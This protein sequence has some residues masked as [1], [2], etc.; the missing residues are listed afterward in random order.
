GYE[1][2]F[3]DEVTAFDVSA[4]PNRYLRYGFLSDFHPA[5]RD[6]ATD[7]D[8]LLRYRI[9]AVQ[10]YDWM[11]RHHEFLPPTE[12]FRDAM[13]RPVDLGAV[14]A[15]LASCRERGQ[16]TLAY[17]AVYGAEAEYI[18]SRPDQRL[19]RADGSPLVF[20]G[21]I[22]F[23]NIAPGNPWVAQIVEQYRRT[24]ADLG[25]DGIH[26]DQYGYPKVAFDA[27]GRAVDLEAAFVN[28]IGE[29]KSALTAVRPDNTVLFN[30]VGD[31][32]TTRVAPA[33]QDG[34][35]I[36]VWD[37]HAT[38][39]HLMALV[40]KAKALAPGKTVILAAYLHCFN[41]PGPDEPKIW[42]A[43]TATAFIAAAG[44]THLLWGETCGALAEGYYVNHRTY[45]PVWE[46]VIRGYCEFPVKYRDW[47]VGQAEDV[48]WDR[49]DG[50]NR[51]FLVEGWT[52]TP[53][54][55]KP[56]LTASLRR[57]PGT[58]VVQLLHPASQGAPVWNARASRPEVV[59]NLTLR[60]LVEGR[61]ARV[62]TASPDFDGGRLFDLPFTQERL[63]EGTATVVVLPRLRLWSL[64][65]IL[66]D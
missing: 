41:E 58:L 7:V 61:P 46:P 45:D 3:G 1:V 16:R 53:D 56:G 4:D 39:G 17:G 25:F 8:Q 9:N 50:P 30:A 26:M 40:R 6:D 20:I 14:K 11:Y 43:L 49:V 37:P 64:V 38:L 66:W 35:Y 29:T 31:W 19:Y 44:G 21:L 15:K 48:S 42:G 65:A 23:C 47:I 33:P 52:V 59:E 54:G 22:G 63:E 32:P 62:V 60:I 34:V 18:D 28:L 5:D 13:G 10:F 51:E 2:E 36:E 55:S 12:V 24:V 57:L 27:T